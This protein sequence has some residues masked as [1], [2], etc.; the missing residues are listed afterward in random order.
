MMSAPG[1]RAVYDEIA[2]KMAIG[3]MISEMRHKKNMTQT[4]LARKVGTSRTAIARYESG[5]Y[6][7]YSIVTLQRIAKAFGR[8]LTISFS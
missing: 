2:G 1:F 3:E 4:E 6:N 8:K 7:R 5:N